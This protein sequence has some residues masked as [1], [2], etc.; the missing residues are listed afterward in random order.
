M[1]AILAAPK[2]VRSIKLTQY[3]APTVRTRRRSMWRMMRL[4][5]DSVMP[6][7]PS[8]ALMA[9]SVSILSRSASVSTWPDFSL[10]WVGETEVGVTDM[11]SDGGLD[12][13]VGVVS[14]RFQ[15]GEVRC[16]GEKK[17]VGLGLEWLLYSDAVVYRESRRWQGRDDPLSILYS[18]LLGHLPCQSCFQANCLPI[19][20]LLHSTLGASFE[21]L[22]RPEATQLT[23]PRPS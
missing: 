6:N 9:A 10:V 19:L 18:T 2:L 15:R 23:P 12:S 20:L 5:S 13:R 4:C 17:M 11:M 7:S 22:C 21:K 8:T 1:P 16:P 3:R 14:C